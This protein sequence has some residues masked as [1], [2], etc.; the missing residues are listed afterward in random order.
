MIF[1]TR[2]ILLT[3]IAGSMNVHVRDTV[4]QQESRVFT[5]SGDQL[6]GWHVE[7]FDISAHNPYKVNS[8]GVHTDRR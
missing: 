6:N 8:Q 1:H 2:Y 3:I 5:K 4:T 7:E